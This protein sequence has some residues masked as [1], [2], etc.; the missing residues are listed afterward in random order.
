MGKEA[1]GPEVVHCPSVGECQC[2][3][4]GVGGWVSTL[5]EAGEGGG[6]GGFRRGDPERGKHLKCK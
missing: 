4:M 1:L 2:G 3:K 6:I 5:I